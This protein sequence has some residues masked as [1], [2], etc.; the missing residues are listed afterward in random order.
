MVCLESRVILG[1]MDWMV[2]QD[3]LV[4]LERKESL[5]LMD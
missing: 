2:F 3:L 4:S 5:D 1:E